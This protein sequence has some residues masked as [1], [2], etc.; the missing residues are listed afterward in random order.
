MRLYTDE[1]CLIDDGFVVPFPRTVNV[2]AGGVAALAEDPVPP[3]ALAA[4]LQRHGRRDWDDARLVDLFADWK[5]PK[6]APLRSIFVV[7]GFG[8]RAELERTT[9]AEVV[10]SAGRWAQCSDSGLERV[11]RLVNALS[12]VA[13]YRIT[14]G[15]P[16][17]TASLIAETLA[18]DTPLAASIAS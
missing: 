17:D 5:R 3:D 11:A 2:R 1:R 16:S 4:A 14:L 8:A 6:P 7:A 10:R 9:R 13:C 12:A 18:R 15:R